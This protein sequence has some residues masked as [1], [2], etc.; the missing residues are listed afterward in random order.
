[1]ED[2]FKVENIDPLT[3]ATT[4][5]ILASITNL[6]SNAVLLRSPV[7]NEMMVIHHTISTIES[8]M[9]LTME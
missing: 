3:K 7:D 5:S 2:L 8:I 4:T 6:P 1:M 9:S